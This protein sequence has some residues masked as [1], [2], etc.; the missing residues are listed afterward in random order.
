MVETVQKDTGQAVDITARILKQIVESVNKASSLVGEVTVATQEQTGGATQ[1][2]E[3]S[4]H[5]QQTTRQLAYAAGEQAKTAKEI[6]EAVDNMNQMTQQVA[7]AGFEQKRGGDIV[8]K[9]VEH[10][11][12]IANQNL[13]ATNQLSDAAISLSKE[14][15]RLQ[16]MSDIFRI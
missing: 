16:L 5:M 2:L 1:I 15:Q 10:I 14:A 6:L 12:E 13:T 11:A 7:Q 9:A 3:T 4:T 8:V